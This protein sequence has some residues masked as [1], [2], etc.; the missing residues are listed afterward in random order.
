ML[1][2]PLGSWR[3][4]LGEI[5]DP[6]LYWANNMSQ[7]LENCD[8]NISSVF[9]FKTNLP[10][11]DISPQTA[12]RIKLSPTDPVPSRTPTGDINIPDPVVY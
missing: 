12:Q 3:P 5:L 6:P 9:V 7:I 11:M 1:A 10:H 2:L 4:L 8:K